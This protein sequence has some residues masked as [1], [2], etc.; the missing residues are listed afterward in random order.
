MNSIVYVTQNPMR[1]D[2]D[3]GQLVHT[4]DLTSARQ[5]GELHVLLPSGPQ[6]I[7]TGP[8]LEQLRN[9]L[10]GFT[11][12]DH[13]LCL[14][15]PAVIAMAAAM[16]SEVNDGVVPLLVW[17]RKVRAYNAV[18]IDIHGRLTATV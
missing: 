1:R 3:S 16:V 5:Y 18:T 9:K 13:L 4:F 2:H 11:D 17:D 10:R 15:D 6:L 14:G 8:A 12:R 7:T